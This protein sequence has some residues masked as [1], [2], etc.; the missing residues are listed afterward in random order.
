MLRCVKDGGR[1]AKNGSDD[2]KGWERGVVSGGDSVKEWSAGEMWVCPKVLRMEE[3]MK[4][5]ERIV[6][7]MEDN[8]K[9]GMLGGA[10]DGGT[11]AKNGSGAW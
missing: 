9:V 2:A 1:D 6:R 10:M 7:R 5:L 3:G 4:W 8:G 11:S